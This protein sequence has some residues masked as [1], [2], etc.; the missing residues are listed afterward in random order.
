MIA[1]V[2]RRTREY[3]KTFEENLKGKERANPAYAFLFDDKVRGHELNSEMMTDRQIPEHH[4][5]KLALDRRH[6]VPT[7][8]PEA[9]DDE[10][11]SHSTL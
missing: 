2:A 6:R 8:P 10:V 1:D 11:S 4:V 9:F 7:P 3:G 5:Y